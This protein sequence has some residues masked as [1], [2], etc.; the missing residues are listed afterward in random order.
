MHLSGLPWRR[1]CCHRLPPKHLSLLEPLG[2]EEHLELCNQFVVQSWYGHGWNSC[3]RLLGSFCQG[4]PGLRVMSM[5]ALGSRSTCSHIPVSQWACIYTLNTHTTNTIYWIVQSVYGLHY[6]VQL[7]NKFYNQVS[8]F[9]FEAQI[10]PILMQG[11]GSLLWNST[12]VWCLAVYIISQ[13]DVGHD[14]LYCSNI[15]HH[16]LYCLCVG[17]YASSILPHCYVCFGQFPHYSRA[18]TSSPWVTSSLAW[19]SAVPGAALMS[20][21]IWK[22]PCCLWCPY[23]FSPSKTPS[24]PV[25]PPQ[26]C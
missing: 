5:P 23:R 1:E 14:A 10:T 24:G 13:S 20:S 11:R 18:W 9:S 6:A 17:S 7:P 22:R 26:N 12:H 21:T 4:L 3:F 16:Y 25:C 8:S 15:K 2:K 19:S